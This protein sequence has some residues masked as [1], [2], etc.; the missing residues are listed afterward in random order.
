MVREKYQLSQLSKAQIINIEM[1]VNNR[2]LI[3]EDNKT[4]GQL[5][6]AWF[7]GMQ[8]TTGNQRKKLEETKKCIKI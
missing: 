5:I 8:T 1:D 6:R 7:M 4:A 2:W 3:R